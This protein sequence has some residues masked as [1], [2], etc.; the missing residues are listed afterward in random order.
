MCAGL[1]DREAGSIGT[2]P[3][4]LVSNA[5]QCVATGPVLPFQYQHIRP[6]PPSIL[7]PSVKQG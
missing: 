5:G 7:P 4:T 2:D 1:D 3:V 6:Y